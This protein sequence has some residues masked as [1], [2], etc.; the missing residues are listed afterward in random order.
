MTDNVFD[1]VDNEAPAPAAIDPNAAPANPKPVDVS[2]LQK[3]LDDSQAFIGQLKQ[4]RANDRQLLDTV[5]QKLEL[6]LRAQQVADDDQPPPH[7]P[8]QPAI[9]AEALR[10]Q[11]FITK[12]DIEAHQRAQVAEAN[13]NAV[14]EIGRKQF[15]D[16]LN[17]HVANKCKAI[18]VSIDWAKAQAAHNPNVFI[19]LFGLKSKSASAPAPVEASISTAQYRDAPAPDQKQSVMFGATTKDVMKEWRRHAPTNE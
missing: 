3:R 2:V 17:E 5:T 1:P 11:G 15:G 13:L 7:V 19:E 16:K 18:G 9:T 14:L 8:A 4:E 6:L 12:E 10:A